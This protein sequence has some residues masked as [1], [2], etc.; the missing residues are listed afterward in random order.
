MWP[1]FHVAAL[2]VVHV[3]AFTPERRQNDLCPVNNRDNCA[4][5]VTG[6]FQ[7][8]AT[9]AAHR[10]DCSSYLEATTTFFPTSITLIF[11]TTT[12]TVSGGDLAKRQ[13]SS[14]K[15][16]PAYAIACNPTSRYAS[17]CYC[18]GITGSTST[19]TESDE[20]V[21]ITSTVNITT[22]L[23]SSIPPSTSRNSTANSASSM[24][25]FSGTAPIITGTGGTGIGTGTGTSG[26]P[27]QSSNSSS[28]YI[29]PCLPGQSLCNDDCTNLQ[30]DN[31]N[32]GSCGLECSG[33]TSCV[34]GSCACPG[35][36]TLCNDCTDLQS[37]SQN[38]GE[39]GTH[40][41]GGSSC[42]NGACTCPGSLTLCD[43]CTNLQTDNRNCGACGRVCGAGTRCRNGDC[44]CIPG[45]C[46]TFGAT[47][48]CNGVRPCRCVASPDGSTF[49]SNNF[50]CRGRRLCTADGRC[51]AGSRCAVATCCVRFGQ[52]VPRVCIPQLYYRQC[53]NPAVKLMV[54]ARDEEDE[55]AE[56]D[57]EGKGDPI[58]ILEGWAFGGNGE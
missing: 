22:T 32:C 5:A 7:G 18:W 28:S 30:L 21:T 36:T 13:T 53:R 38:C 40:C 51:P 4:R 2:L 23:R 6:T 56:D 54:L 14:T 48:G 52:R 1:S 15:N 50:P 35:N 37:D 10:R 17:A 44:Q 57:L 9:V 33:G 58:E 45:R 46:G 29:P 41:S 24:T 3:C 34:E 31:S 20:V 12:I 19:Y 43:D 39:C 26:F 11:V 25:S 55:W 16:I 27:P 42:T 47:L 8:S 49:C